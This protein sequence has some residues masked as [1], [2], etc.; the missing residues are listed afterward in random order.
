MDQEALYQSK[1][2]Q[3]ADV[4]TRKCH[5]SSS[6]LYLSSHSSPYISAELYDFLNTHRYFR[7]TLEHTS[8]PGSLQRFPVLV[9]GGDC[10]YLNKPRRC[11]TRRESLPGQHKNYAACSLS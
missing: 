3:Y 11:N 2:R 1:L 7:C 5:Y 6:L 10:T 4:I 9:L 8:T